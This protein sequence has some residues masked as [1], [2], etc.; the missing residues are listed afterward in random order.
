MIRLI[1]FLFMLL[2]VP[3]VISAQQPAAQPGAVQREAGER[4]TLAK[5][6]EL[7]PAV[8]LYKELQNVPDDIRRSAPFARALYEMTRRAGLDG[9]FDREERYQAFQQSQ[10]DLE[11]SSVAEKA[12]G[13]NGGAPMKPLAN[14][15]TNIGLIG[16]PNNYVFSAGCISAIAINPTTPNIMYAGGTS[17]G[18]WK[19]TDAGAHWVPLTDNAIPNLSVSSIAIDPKH[20]NTLYVG[21]GNGY[22]SIDELTG[23]GLY[24]SEDGGG[25]W[26]RIGAASLTG[27]VVKVLVDPIKSNVVFAAQYSGAR[28]LYRSTDSGTTWTKVFPT[29]G[30]SAGVV[31]D[32][33]ATVVGGI[34]YL[35]FAE[36]NHIPLATSQECGVYKSVDDGATWAKYTTQFPRGDTIGRCGLAASIS[37]PKRLFVL[38]T[39]TGGDIIAGGSR[40]LFRTTDNGLTWG[41]IV[42]PT[43]VFHGGSGG[44]IQPAQGWY[45]LMLGVTPFSNGTT[46]SDTIYVGGVEAWVNCNDGNGWQD[47]SD[48][49]WSWAYS[50]VDHHSI[51]FNPQDPSIVFDGCDGGLYW[52]NTAGLPGEWSYRSNQMQTGR[53]YHIGLDRQVANYVT[54]LGGAQDQGT[55]K[56]QGSTTPVLE[57]GGDGLQPISNS[58]N[59]TYPYYGELPNGDLYRYNNSTHV[60]SQIDTESTDNAYWDTPF[61][62]SIAPFGNIAAYHVFYAGRQHLW[63]SVN[64]GS[65]WSMTSSAAFRDLI[66]AVGL[67]ATSSNNIYVG[68]WDSI[69]SSQDAGASWTAKHTGSSAWVTS[70]VTTG[71]DDQ[72]ALASFGTSGTNHVMRTTD[73]GAHWASRNGSTGHLL[74]AVGVNCVAVDSVDPLRIW[75]AATDNGIYYTIDSGLTWSVAGSGMGLVPCYDV[76]VQANKINIR[77]ATFG[78]GIWEGFTNT[79]PVELS[80][81]AYRK[82]Q[83]GTLLSW[84]TDSERGDAGFFVQ[85]S[86]GGAAFEDI[87]PAIIQSKSG[88]GTSNTRLDYNFLDTL[89]AAG[90]YL[91]QLK[92][93]DLDGSIHFSNNVEVHWGGNQMVVYQSYPNPLMIGTPTSTIASAFQPFGPDNTPVVQPALATRID[94]ELPYDETTDGDAISIKIYNSLG[95]FVANAVDPNGTPVNNLAQPA[96]TNSAFWDGHASDGAIAPS[97]AYFYTIETQHS[98]TF[99]GKMVLYSN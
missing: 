55:W 24:K 85:R 99:I 20:P 89:R 62:Q 92:Q 10:R 65:T 64:D 13:Q 28:G 93:V 56:I 39:N 70:I 86:Y 94:Y 34:P 79:L 36:G 12:S 66:H 90:T 45:D 21:T 2:A 44:P 78:R 76:Q 87:N 31:W 23:T 33:L 46:G 37:D 75:Y 25:T 52:T 15:W 22:A 54:T 38:I 68:T 84:H 32:V 19:S 5:P 73:M 98:G 35:Y 95:K 53:F 9:T 72:F 18:V 74:P 48:N 49:S 97:G 26:K 63:R 8:G 60:W 91:Y 14:A 51:A 61:K 6:V 57:L 47:Y 3:T 82:T 67:S 29:S 88:G 80:S 16:S 4:E 1:V 27:T 69:Y 40:D 7:P 96:G 81:L 58:L 83:S 50:H 42:I 59:T 11:Q 71:H 43:T 77:V 41:S 30:Y 17:G